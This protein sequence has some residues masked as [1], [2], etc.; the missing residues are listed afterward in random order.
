M[1]RCQPA[2]AC[3]RNTLRV[4]EPCTKLS[5]THSSCCHRLASLS[6]QFRPCGSILRCSC[7][8]FLL[9]LLR[10]QIVT[11]HATV[12]GWLLFLL[13]LSQLRKQISA[14]AAS[15]YNADHVRTVTLLSPPDTAAV[16]CYMVHVRTLTLL[17]SP[18]DTNSGGP[19]CSG[20]QLFT[21]AVCSD[22]RFTCSA[23][24]HCSA[25]EALR[26]RNE[27]D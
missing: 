21:I 4:V 17:S 14:A 9:Q 19:R 13:Q 11:P 23:L 26:G 25:Q 20:Q 10:S 5:S 24:Q 12:A 27:C 7:C 1:W 2:V 16:L 18:P 8:R 3:W 6:Q 22:S 15:C